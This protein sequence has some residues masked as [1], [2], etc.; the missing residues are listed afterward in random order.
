MQSES[1]QLNSW[2]IKQLK[3]MVSTAV[4]LLEFEIVLMKHAG[5]ILVFPSG[6]YRSNIKA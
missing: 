6:T 5:V 2:T 4:K 3:K 1:K